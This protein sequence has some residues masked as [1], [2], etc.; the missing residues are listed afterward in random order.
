MPYKEARRLAQAVIY[1]LVLCGVQQPGPTNAWLEKTGL[2]RQG[3]CLW[4]R[5]QWRSSLNDPHAQPELLV[6][7][8]GAIA[9]AVP[10]DGEMLPCGQ[11][12]LAEVDLV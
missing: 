3:E 4:V 9:K 2:A 5:P 12:Q 8:L 10:V 1:A 11:R 6:L 7:W